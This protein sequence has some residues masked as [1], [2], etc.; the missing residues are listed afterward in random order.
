MKALFA[1]SVLAAAASALSFK[2]DPFWKAYK[3]S[4]GK[5]YES[6][7]EE[8]RRYEVFTQNMQMA[9]E[10]NAHESEFAEYGMT[11]VS[12][13]FPE[14][15]FTELD[16]PEGIVRDAEETPI[17]EAP[18]SYDSRNYGYVPA[19]RN[20]GQCGSCWAFSTVASM[21]VNY[22]KKHRV[23]PPVLSEQQLVDCST[24]DHGCS[25]GWPTTAAN[26]AKK[27]VML[28]SA[29][30]YQARAG[31]CKYVSSKVK[32]KVTSTG[33]T[34]T[35]VSAIKSAVQTYGSLMVALN[36]K[37]MQQYNNGIITGYNCPTN[38]NHAVN[39]VGW[40]KYSSYEYWI[41]RN[42]WGTG[43]GEKGYFRILTGRNACGI[44]SYP[45]YVTVA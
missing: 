36:A 43:W 14:E 21:S 22:A 31:S 39:I 7:A 32:A 2:A 3:S 28:N 29:Y 33:Y 34:G 24:G 11:P 12:D 5:S 40:G 8:A 25:G 1:L 26:Y 13:R 38:V 4:F 23:T 41:V 44:E 42:S 37:I 10:L 9:A 45:M 30:S 18:T 19:I 15:L 35:S 16:I 17:V 27:G 6:D 20:Q